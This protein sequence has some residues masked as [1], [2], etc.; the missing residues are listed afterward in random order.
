[1]SLPKDNSNTPVTEHKDTEF[2]NLANK[3]FKLAVFTNSTAYK[4]QQTY[5]SIKSG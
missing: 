1:M 3:E 2:I 5:K 4:N